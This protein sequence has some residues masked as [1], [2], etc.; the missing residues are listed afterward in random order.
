MRVCVCV[1]CAFSLHLVCILFFLLFFCFAV[2]RYTVN[3]N[4][5][6]PIVYTA[7]HVT[8]FHQ[9]AGNKRCLLRSHVSL[10]C[11]P[12]QLV[13]VLSKLFK[14][15]GSSFTVP[16]K[17][18]PSSHFFFLTPTLVSVV[19]CHG[20]LVSNDD[21]VH[22]TL[23][24]ASSKYWAGR[25]GCTCFRIRLAPLQ[26]L[27]SDPGTERRGRGWQRGGGRGFRA[28]RFCFVG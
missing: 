27:L 6:N 10:F 21:E 16:E 19:G 9:S 11:M 2:Y 23:I 7:I 17:S 25:M 18:E 12:K 22:I 13:K 26:N 15:R 14:T 24:S 28:L 5:K 4:V 1:F 20:E 3:S 8:D